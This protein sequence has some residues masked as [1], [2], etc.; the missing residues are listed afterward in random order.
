[1]FYIKDMNISL[2]TRF[3][4]DKS[5]F[6]HGY[7]IAHFLHCHYWYIPSMHQNIYILKKETDILNP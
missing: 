4:F 2:I 1:M 6:S 7:A 5:S 3:E